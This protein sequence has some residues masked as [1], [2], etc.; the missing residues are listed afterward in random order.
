TPT[1]FHEVL[2]VILTLEDLVVT[3][4]GSTLIVQPAA[5]A[6]SQAPAPLGAPE[7]REALFHGLGGVPADEL[8]SVITTL[9]PGVT[10]QSVNGGTRLL[11]TATPDQHDTIRELIREYQAHAQE[12]ATIEEE[13][14]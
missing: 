7:A 10:A 2:T 3:E 14:V 12:D 11:I 6:G 9:H 13:P 5:T 8:T 4:T 1:P